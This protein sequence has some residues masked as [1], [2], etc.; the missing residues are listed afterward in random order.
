MAIVIVGAPSGFSIASPRSVGS[1]NVDWTACLVTL[2][3]TPLA[4][5][6]LVAVQAVNPYSAKVWRKPSWQVNPFLF[7]DPLQFFHLAAYHFMVAGIVGCLTLF[8]RG[9]EAAPLAVWLLSIGMGLW[10]GMQLSLLIFRRK[11]RNNKA[12]AAK[13]VESGEGVR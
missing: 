6:L 12:Q 10:L 3:F 8:Y 11:L 13:S 9:K 5:L 4:V 2:A 7:K 1:S